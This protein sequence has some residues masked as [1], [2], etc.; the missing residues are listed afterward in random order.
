MKW[1]GFILWIK[2][3]F[4]NHSAAAPTLF[5][6]IQQTAELCLGWEVT[7]EV[8][9]I[10]EQNVEK[11][12]SCHPAIK[13][14]N[15]VFAHVQDF[16]FQWGCREYRALINPFT[17]SIINFSFALKLSL[18]LLNLCVIEHRESAP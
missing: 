11:P 6:R 10:V 4:M 3:N 16:D 14:H 13:K 17:S 5:V 18:K 1:L 8:D 2:T 7:V 15:P 12:Y 9:E